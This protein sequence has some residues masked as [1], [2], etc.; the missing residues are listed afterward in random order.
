MIKGR[1]ICMVQTRPLPGTYRNRGERIDAITE[2][3]LEET[4][5][6]TE[7]GVQTVI[8]QNMGDMPVK[9]QAFPET[10]AYLSVVASSIRRHFP[11]IALGVLVNW[12]GVAAMAVADAAG[13]DFI[14]VEHLY[15]GAEV[16]SAGIL[17]GQCCEITALK[18]KIGTDLPIYADLW[19]THGI[20]IC[21]QPLDEAA[22]EC[23][24]EAFADGLF[25]C[26]K[27]AQRSIEMAVAVRK[28]LPDIPLFL[29]G[30]A[31]GDNVR[32]LIQYYD[33]A[34]VATWIKNGN[35]SNPIDPDRTR[36]FVEQA[37]LAGDRICI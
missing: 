34:C 8:L 36:Y 6:L 26:G 28:R 24:H 2:Q 16:T 11:D 3:A 20:P 15:T 18:K 33:A 10:I 17:Q 13:A 4:R 31:T 12:D 27:T 35:M 7:C 1:V 19:E 9:Q 21:P 5:I 25:M 32:E 37:A 23:V 30:G 22:W 29:G 14:R